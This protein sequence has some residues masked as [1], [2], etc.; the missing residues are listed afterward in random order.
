MHRTMTMTGLVLLTIAVV[1]G[2]SHAIPP[3]AINYQGVLRDSA[4][5]PLDG[6]LSRTWRRFTRIRRSGAPDW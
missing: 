5:N 6:T 1:V 3:E 4:G 2:V